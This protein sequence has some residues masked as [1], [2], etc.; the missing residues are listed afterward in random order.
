M[1]F[2]DL[3]ISHV[4][5][6]PILVEGRLPFGF[7][8]ELE[9]VQNSDNS[10]NKG[11]RDALGEHPQLIFEQTS[12]HPKLIAQQTSIHPQPIARDAAIISYMTED[13]EIIDIG[14]ENTNVEEDVIH[15]E[16]DSDLPSNLDSSESELDVI[17][18]EDDSELDEELRAFRTERTRKNHHQKKSKVFVPALEVELGESRVEKGF[19]NI[20]YRLNKRDK[21][22]GILGEMRTTIVLRYW[23]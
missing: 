18:E 6:Q 13:E 9:V 4:V 11:S 17:P 22:V 7:L 3:F 10:I 5:N 8:S 15:E 20:N 16:D 14:D 21:Y 19:N 12:V 2:L 1:L 23:K